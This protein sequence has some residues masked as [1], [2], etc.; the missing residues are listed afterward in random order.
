MALETLVSQ[1][2]QGEAVHPGSGLHS[3]R[4]REVTSVS[5]QALPAPTAALG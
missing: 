2:H 3:F 4:D 1:S 5:D